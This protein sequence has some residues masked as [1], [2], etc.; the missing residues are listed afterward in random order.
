MKKS[1]RKKAFSNKLSDSEIER[2]AILIEEAA[3]VQQV[4][5]KI[6]RHGYESH[7]PRGLTK[8]RQLLTREIG[9]L[10][11]AIELVMEARDVQRLGVVTSAIEKVTSLR[12]FTHHQKPRDLDEVEQ[13]WMNVAK[14][15]T[16]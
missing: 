2:L 1:G 8:N 12:E 10:E 14:A 5:C 3:E 13:R 6:L 15:S 4:A 7:H 9:D 11:T 16:R